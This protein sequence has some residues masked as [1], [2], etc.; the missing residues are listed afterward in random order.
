M[1]TT[2][3]I[4]RAVRAL[5]APIFVVGLEWMVSGTNKIIGNFVGPF[6]AYV[7]SLQAAHTFLPGLSLAVQFPLLAARLAIA[8]EI[9]L[10]VA[11][12]LSSFFFLRGANRIW[13][14]VAG[15]ALAASAFVS[16]GLWLLIGRPPFWPTGNGFQSGWPVE[17]FLVA[18]SVALAIAIALADPEG[19]LVMRARRALR[20][21]SEKLTNHQS[22]A[23]PN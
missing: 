3:K 1:D 17:F 18:I 14:V 23:T 16:T 5:S 11:L 13:E 4:S 6:A 7:S 20:R 21:R 10:G 2:P 9:A 22:T 12:V 15:T 19:T 8:T